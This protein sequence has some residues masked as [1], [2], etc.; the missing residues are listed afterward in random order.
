MGTHSMPVAGKTVFSE[1]LGPAWKNP[2]RMCGYKWGLLKVRKENIKGTW[3]A[4]GSESVPFFFRCFK[5]YTNP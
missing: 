2:S 1:N 5:T 3:W 4:T